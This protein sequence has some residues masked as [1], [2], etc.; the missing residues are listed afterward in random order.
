MLTHNNPQDTWPNEIQIEFKSYNLKKKKLTFILK[1]EKPNGDNSIHL[2]NTLYVRLPQFLEMNLKIDKVNQIFV[3]SQCGN[4]ES[5]LNEMKKCFLDHGV[6]EKNWEEFEKKLIPKKCVKPKQKFDDL[7]QELKIDSI[8]SYLDMPSVVSLAK[9]SHLFMNSLNK[10]WSLRQSFL[11]LGCDPKVVNHV[12]KTQSVKDYEHLYNRVKSLSLPER[13][14]MKAWQMLCLSGAE[15][16]IRNAIIYEGLT[17]ETI[18]DNMS[19]PLHWAAFSGKACGIRA[20]VSNFLNLNQL[21]VNKDG[22]NA[23]HMALLS[24][25]EE[26]LEEAGA[27]HNINVW[28]KDNDGMNILHNAALGGSSAVMRKI[29]S[30]TEINPLEKTSDGTSVLHFAAW[31]GDTDAI[32]E[33][34]TI[35][36]INIS[37]LDQEGRS[38]LHYAAWS[39]SAAAILLIRQKLKE[40]HSEINENSKDIDGDDIFCYIN[41]SDALEDEKVA[42]VEALSLPLDKL[43]FVSGKHRLY[44]N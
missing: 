16:A 42:A 37:A 6:K 24:G 25:S 3:V 8:A 1:T 19:G 30:S 41:D 28:A 40:V 39:G 13:K 36:G 26:A 5:F 35:P 38:V 15:E 10:L 29:M 11:E 18:D 12:I 17:A 32:N 14:K 33:A 44:P 22:A 23:L 7:P 31:S 4:I 21:A 34:L 43:D 27:I 9:T 20:V 2:Q